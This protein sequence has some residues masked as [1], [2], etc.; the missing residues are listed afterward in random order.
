MAPKFQSVRNS[1]DMFFWPPFRYKHHLE[2]NNVDPD[3][4]GFGIQK[5]IQNLSEFILI[6]TQK[7]PAVGPG[8]PRH[9]NQNCRASLRRSHARLPGFDKKDYLG[10][11][12]WI[13]GQWNQE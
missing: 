2:K 7:N 12:P 11:K 6:L 8:S 5:I 3:S 4:I 13:E 1:G 10:G 9:T